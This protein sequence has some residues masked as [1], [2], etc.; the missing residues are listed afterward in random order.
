MGIVLCL[1]FYQELTSLMKKTWERE[2]QTFNLRN[3]GQLD[4]VKQQ[5]NNGRNLPKDSLARQ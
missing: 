3:N 2:D 1:S 5:N 4:N